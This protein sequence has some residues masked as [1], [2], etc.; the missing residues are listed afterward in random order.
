VRPADHAQRQKHHRTEKQEQ[1]SDH[2]AE[3]SGSVV[4]DCLLV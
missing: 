1:T 4:D 2:H 3:P